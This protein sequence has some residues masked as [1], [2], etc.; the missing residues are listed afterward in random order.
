M[1]VILP[2]MFV[3][4][5]ASP[6]E[7]NP[8]YD[9]I[10]TQSETWLS[11]ECSFSPKFQHTLHQLDFSYF[12]SVVIP[13]ASFTK[14]RPLCD[15]GNWVFPFDDAFDNGP[16]QRDPAGAQEMVD[17]CLS[18]I[19]GR[20]AAPEQPI[21]HAF[22]SIWD[23]LSQ[24]APHGTQKRFVKYMT[25]FCESNIDQVTLH[26]A[27]KIPTIDRLIE[28]RRGSIGA[29][30]IFALVEYA[31]DLELPDSVMQ[32]PIIEKLGEIITDI[33]LIQNDIV[34][35][36]KEQDLGENHNLVMVYLLKVG[37]IT[38]AFDECASLLHSRYR[39]WYSVLAQVPFW[40]EQIDSQVQQY[41]SG[42]RNVAAANLN[43]SFRT[44]RYWY[45][46]NTRV[47]QTRDVS[48]LV[49][50]ERSAI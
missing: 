6:P 45:G 48:M 31:Y 19:D 39:E 14:L 49:K 50:E 24:Q 33:V 5:L 29:T 40:N 27:S 36:F 3:S 2:D 42:I 43:W 17:A 26:S 18:I 47:R 15:W 23:R 8:H 37:D 30:P 10:R 11:R 34:S 16:L 1:P 25:T 35:Y 9:T 41:I 22:K 20:N 12:C 4:F 13:L 21:L 38:T 28:L 32:H 46:H 7:I 44:D